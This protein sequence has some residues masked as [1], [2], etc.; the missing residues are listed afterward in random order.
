MSKDEHEAVRQALAELGNEFSRNGTPNQTAI[1]DK[2]G[3]SQQAV[4]RAL[5]RDKFGPEF[6]RA[7]AIWKGFENVGQLVDHY[8]GE[9]APR[10]GRVMK[11]DPDDPQDRWAAAK[12]AARGSRDDLERDGVTVEN[13]IAHV[14]KHQAWS[15][16]PEMTALAGV[17]LIEDAIKTLARARRGQLAEK[18]RPVEDDELA[19]PRRR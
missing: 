12:L 7:V 10:A 17:R 14:E 8:R 5:S 1:A 3:V 4:S 13:G 11:L 16:M 2:I 9:G 19:S 6:A 15:N 18:G